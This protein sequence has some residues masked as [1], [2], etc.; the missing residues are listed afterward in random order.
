MV[1]PEAGKA[2]VYVIQDDTLWQAH[3]RPSTIVGLD[4]HWV[5]ATRANSYFYPSTDPGDH[6]ICVQWQ[7][8]LIVAMH[9]RESSRSAAIH[10]ILHSEGVYYVT[11]QDIFPGPKFPR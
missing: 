10:L 5:G 9:S 4:G 8:S 1:M 2:L 7:S 11:I 6:N 3:P